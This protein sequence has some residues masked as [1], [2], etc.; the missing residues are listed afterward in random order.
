M[1]YKWFVGMLIVLFLICGLGQMMD[2]YNNSQCRT[3]AIHRGMSADDIL[4]ICK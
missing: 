2:Q 3:I 1:E 4:R